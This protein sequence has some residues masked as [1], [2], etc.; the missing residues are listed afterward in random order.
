M[1]VKLTYSIYHKNNYKS[2]YNI[3]FL[4]S[5]INAGINKR[6][7]ILLTQNIIYSNILYPIL[8]KL[9]YKNIK[10]VDILISITQIIYIIN[11]F[12]LNIMKLT[13]LL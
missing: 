9:K 4:Y 2:S 12:I 11:L 5:N 7:S 3:L 10:S 8:N 6:H 1:Q 13:Y